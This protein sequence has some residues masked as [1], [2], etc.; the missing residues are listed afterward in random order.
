MTNP[1]PP[2]SCTFTP[3]LPELFT[4]LGCTLVISTY[5]AGKVIF[6]SPK[7]DETFIQ[8]PRDFA[9]AMAIGISKNRIAVA[10]VN[11]VVVLAHDPSLAPGYPDKPNTYDTLF[12]PRATYYT[13]QI[14]IHGLAWGTE[15][16][17]TANTSFSSLA[18]ID[19]SY[20]FVPRWKPSFISELAG[21]DRCHL[22]GM[23]MQ[24]GSPLFVTA[25]GTG[26]APQSWRKTIP[27]GGVVMNVP[28]NSIVLNDLP[29]P[30]SPRLFDGKLYLLFS[31]TGE[32]VQ[33]DP[34][35]GT[36]D[37][38]NRISGFVRGMCKYKDYLFVGLSR[39]RQNSSTFK[40]LPIAKKATYAG[41]AVIHLPTGGLV[42][43]RK[44][45]VL[46]IGN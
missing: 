16:L 10:S 35:K 1:P 30:H 32:V 25:M 2:F 14:D 33:A 8:L 13:G 21:E 4:Q 41:V 44:S 23:A 24:D 9:H 17:W 5:Q 12:V 28:E 29:M 3:S 34:E 45:S 22:N 39:L 46:R 20:S 42:R 43:R 40:D 19:D 38:I 15:G 27:G 11:E 26:D 36:Y 6:L 37:V 7:G 31:A 18:L